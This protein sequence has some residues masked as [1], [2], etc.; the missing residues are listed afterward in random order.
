MPN[1]EVY[2][3]PK[4]GNA[5]QGDAFCP[6]VLA[7]MITDTGA[8]GL[9]LDDETIDKLATEEL[10]RESTPQMRDVAAAIERR[11]AVLRERMKS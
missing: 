2:G 6:Q 9:V 3:C 8:N 1:Y 11:K 5:H 7:G 10:A 4:C